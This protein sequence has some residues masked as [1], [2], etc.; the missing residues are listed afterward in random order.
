MPG[1]RKQLV[2]SMV[3]VG[4]R[5]IPVDPWI[6]EV[7]LAP[8]DQ[9]HFEIVI[10]VSKASG[11]YAPSRA[12]C[13]GCQLVCLKTLID[14]KTLTSA[15]NDIDFVWDR[16]VDLSVLFWLFLLFLSLS[17]N[18]EGGGRNIPFSVPSGLFVYSQ[19]IGTPHSAKWRHGRLGWESNSVGVPAAC[20][21][22]SPKPRALQEEGTL[23]TQALGVMDFPMARFWHSRIGMAL[24]LKGPNDASMMPLVPQLFVPRRKAECSYT[25]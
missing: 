4:F 13:H 10:Q 25:S 14:L 3:D 2:L 22:L 5:P 16:H 11:D 18:N 9:K 23:A 15:Y 19:A 8:L 1:L 20:S 21:P 24:T 12:P 6:V 7:V 17:H